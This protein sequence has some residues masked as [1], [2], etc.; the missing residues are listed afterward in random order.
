MNVQG[1]TSISGR[2]SPQ[3]MEFE[4]RLPL[5]MTLRDEATWWSFTRS[6]KLSYMTYLLQMMATGIPLA[7]SDCL[8][9]YLVGAL[10]NS[11]FG[12]FGIAAN[13]PLASGFAISV[14]LLHSCFGL[15]PGIALNRVE[16]FR[17]LTLSGFA[18][19]LLSLAFSFAVGPCI[20]CLAL[21]ASWGLLTALAPMTRWLTRVA[22]SRFDWWCQPVMVMASSEDAGT[23][24]SRLASN[25]TLGIRPVRTMVIRPDSM[26]T[27][28]T[29][30][31]GAAV[32]AP[33]WNESGERCFWVAA[34]SS[35][36]TRGAVLQKVR[37]MSIPHLF[38]VR[39][40]DDRILPNNIRICTGETE[41]SQ[42][43]P[44]RQVGLA[45]KRC[46]DF[47]VSSAGGLLLLPLLI[48]VAAA[49]KLTSRGPIFY[50][51]PRLGINNSR[52][53][54]WKFRSMVP[55]AEVRLRQYLMDHPEERPDF[56]K[57]FKLKKDPRITPIGKWLRL[58]S[59]DELPQIWNV[60]TGDMSLVGPR[61]VDVGLGAKAK[62]ENPTPNSNPA[63]NLPVIAGLYSE[64]ALQVR[65]G[66]TGL[67]QISGRADTSQYERMDLDC[68]Y[69]DH[70]S[71]WLDFYILLCTPAVVLRME[72]AR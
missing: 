24:N 72:G 20:P 63:S 34:S 57:Y 35:L 58:L 7:L 41:E 71:L 67:W 29:S 39:A 50:G 52:Y 62:T 45:T 4:S 3:M 14:L 17:R 43:N 37:D 69:V 15:Y 60:I 65:P 8:F 5:G 66:I 12:V 11:V 54:M 70:W 51:T 44:M 49:V 31:T 27:E 32:H 9:S 61:P 18:G 16:E 10:I 38:W 48:V 28:V 47:L 68:E 33:S 55:D 22:F 42:R 64:K 21:V 1:D 19:V 2:S 56:E 13:L 30:S 26:P 6:E 46:F 53:R 25:R 36:T 23:M 40:Q 59:I